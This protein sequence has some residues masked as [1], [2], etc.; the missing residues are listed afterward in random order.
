ME[1]KDYQRKCLNQ[2]KYYLE[3][4][5]VYKKKYDGYIKDDPDMQYNYEFPKITWDKCNIKDY[6]D[7]RA[8]NSKRWVE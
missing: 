2:I 3:T 6:K 4:L 5:A 7:E 1:V 8:L